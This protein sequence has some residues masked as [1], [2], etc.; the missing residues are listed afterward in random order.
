M[1]NVTQ[2]SFAQFYPVT[3]YISGVVTV[4]G[5]T[6]SVASLSGNAIGQALVSVTDTAAGQVT[7]VVDNF[8]GPQG[9]ALGRGTTSQFAILACSTGTYSGNTAS[10]AF[11]T[12][13]P[14]TSALADNISFNFELWAY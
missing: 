7:V 2:N 10:F 9:I 5:G 11:A 1:S 4:S 12:F 13:D 6:P 3:G 14:L 8:K